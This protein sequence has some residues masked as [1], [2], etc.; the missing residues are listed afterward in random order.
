M[1]R[2]FYVRRHRARTR[3]TL[4][5]RDFLCGRVS[6]GEPQRAVIQDV[7]CSSLIHANRMERRL[8]LSH[9]GA[10]AGT[11]SASGQHRLLFVLGRTQA[12]FHTTRLDR[13]KTAA[14]QQDQ[15]GT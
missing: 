8:N 14:Q 3:G 13:P 6:A 4:R 2:A 12:S 5:A 10:A 1:N 9:H 15:D 7:V 11:T